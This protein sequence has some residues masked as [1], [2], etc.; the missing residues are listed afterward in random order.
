MQAGRQETFT[1]LI[2]RVIIL[3]EMWRMAKRQVA[4]KK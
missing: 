1:D 4:Q 2:F 3:A